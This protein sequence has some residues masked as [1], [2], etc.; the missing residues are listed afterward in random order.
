MF[1]SFAQRCKI[2]KQDVLSV[3]SEDRCL[4]IR[5]KIW[6]DKWDDKNMI[7]L[8]LWAVYWEQTQI[9][10]PQWRFRQ[11]WKTT[12]HRQVHMT[13][14]HTIK[15]IVVCL[16]LSH[17]WQR[18]CP[19]LFEYKCTLILHGRTLLTTRWCHSLCASKNWV[20]FRGQNSIVNRCWA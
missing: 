1:S 18:R 17:L 10:H 15:E 11:F 2:L 9:Q 20:R 14:S 19:L 4:D 6:D 12:T 3:G 8:N 13:P 7:F 16:A 5:D